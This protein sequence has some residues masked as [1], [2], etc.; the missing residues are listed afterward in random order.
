MLAIWSLF[1]T[2]RREGGS[3]GVQ[4]FYLVLAGIL[5]APL[6]LWLAYLRVRQRV[7]AGRVTEV[8]RR[9][10]RT[11]ARFHVE[12]DH[13]KF[14]R[15]SAV[16]T[17]LNN[18]HVVLTAVEEA[19]GNDPAA[20]EELRLRAH[21]FV[22]EIIPA[23]KPLN[24]YGVGLRLAR[25]LLN[26][27]YRVDVDPAQVERLR[28]LGRERPRALVYVANHRSNVD[29]VLAAYALAEKLALSF[30]VGEWARVWPLEYLFKSFGSFFLR[31]GYRDPLYH[32]VL[33]RYVQLI[34]KNGVTQALFP[35]GGLSRDGRF[36]PPKLGLIDA[37]IC[38]KADRSFTRELL[39]VPV[40]IS[41]DRVLEDRALVA[42]L[43]A[44]RPRRSK[45]TMAWHVLR[46]LFA[47]AAKFRARQLHKNG[48]AAVRFGEPLS[49]DAWHSSL[50]LDLFNLSKEQRRAHIADFCNTL[51]QRMGAL[52]PATPLCVV[53][54]ALLEDRP[55]HRVALEQAVAQHVTALQARGVEV[56]SADRGAGWMVEG[57]MLRFGLRGLVDEST[58]DLRLGAGAEPILR[59][60]ANVLVHV[61]EGEVPRVQAP[62]PTPA[63]EPDAA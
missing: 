3:R 57:A 6:V 45:L 42:E 22:D 35:E 15:Q 39:F 47:N 58:G 1:L 56:I 41:Y 30:A 40:A 25:W 49:F 54:R 31:R 18:D 2:V 60:Y 59:Y 19:A 4:T 26:A 9:F 52:L 61:D 13:F 11:L 10:E 24:Y 44:T 55:A 36:R 29:Y 33:A 7:L 28:Q 51:M 14:A 50:G 5:I 63:A 23:F 32:T 48:I 16:R 37:I 8:E 62:V 21:R 34:T 17:L 12:I 20:R 27:L 46:M 53:A 43:D 38:A